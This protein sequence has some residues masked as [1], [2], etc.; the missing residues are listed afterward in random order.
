MRARRPLC[1]ARPPAPSRFSLQSRDGTRHGDGCRF[2]GGADRRR[3]G[4]RRVHR[5]SRSARGTP[6]PFSC[7][8]LVAS[9]ATVRRPSIT[10][11]SPNTSTSGGASGSSSS[12][13]PSRS[14]SG[15]C[16]S[17]PHPRISSSGSA[18]SAMPPSLCSGS[19]HAQS[20][21]SSA[22]S[23]HTRADR[24]GRLGGNRVRADDRLRRHLARLERRNE[25]GAV[26][27]T[28]VGREWRHARPDERRPA[29]RA[30]VCAIVNAVLPTAALS[31]RR[32]DDVAAAGDVC[33]RVRYGSKRQP[34]K[35][36]M[37][38]SGLPT[39]RERRDSN[40]RPPA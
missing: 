40:P 21:R 14:S 15:P 18:C 38:A 26:V 16:S 9:A 33:A 36:V 39:E 8:L 32:S 13:A 6:L 29:L 34:S 4:G 5:C 20:E 22:P 37:R 25:A 19:S 10:P 17:W 2:D 12:R 7:H 35:V 30:R 11:S 23:R 28:R 27:P 31:T 3:S 1:R 24:P